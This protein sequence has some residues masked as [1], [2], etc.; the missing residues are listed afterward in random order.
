M[1][2]ILWRTI[3]VRQG[4]GRGEFTLGAAGVA[5]LLF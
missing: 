3:C 1:S 4:V 5:H 2:G